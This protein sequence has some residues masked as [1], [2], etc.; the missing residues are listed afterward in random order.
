MS[1]NQ[2]L[3]GFPIPGVIEPATTRTLCIVIPDHDDYHRATI[4]QLTMLGKWWKWKRTSATTQE[5]K[6]TAEHWRDTLEYTLVGEECV[7]DMPFA[8]RM[9]GCDLEY[10]ANGMDWSLVEG[11]DLSGCIAGDTTI[12]N[13]GDSVT[14]IENNITNVQ[15]DITNIENNIT[16]I[17]TETTLITQNINNIVE[18]VGGLQCLFNHFVV[19]N[20]ENNID[21]D[22]NDPFEWI[23]VEFIGRRNNASGNTDLLIA[24]N[25]D[26]TNANYDSALSNN[27]RRVGPITGSAG[28]SSSV[29]RVLLHNPSIVGEHKAMSSSGVYQNS[30]ATTVTSMSNNAVFWKDDSIVSKISLS[31]TDGFLA[32]S[33]VRAYGMSCTAIELDETPEIGWTIELDFLTDDY[34]E[35]VIPIDEAVFESGNGYVSAGGVTE[36]VDLF[37]DLQ[38]SVNILRIETEFFVASPSSTVCSLVMVTPTPQT[39]VLDQPYPNDTDTMSVDINE[40]SQN[41]RLGMEHDGGFSITEMQWRKVRFSGSG[42]IPAALTPYQV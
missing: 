23:I 13:L 6:L 10:S 32:G 33:S 9:N 2:K 18:G 37:F 8:L 4:A 27:N 22:I 7:I 25:D 14:N 1:D 34:D 11:W 5:A 26:T 17:N 39:L 31:V 38:E 35:L 30:A 41:L 28:D 21:I 42:T 15:N 16:N 19:S 20:G 36:N 40:T 24:L 12:I 3:R 29:I